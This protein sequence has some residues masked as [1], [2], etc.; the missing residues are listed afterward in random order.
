LRFG[1]LQP[2]LLAA[3]DGHLYV[4]KFQNNPQ[5][6][7]VLA[8][9]MIA[10]RIALWLDLPMAHVC[11]IEVSESLVA[12]NPLLR[13]ECES[14]SVPCSSGIQLGSRCVAHPDTLLNFDDLNSAQ[15]ESVNNLD[16]FTQVLVFDRW[17]GNCDGRQAVVPRSLR[18]KH[19]GC[20]ATFIDQHYCFNGQAWDFPDLPHTGLCPK[21]SVYRN[22]RGWESFEPMLSRLEAVDAT[23][24]WRLARETPAQWYE[25]N[26][27]ALSELIDTLDK[28]RSMVSRLIQES[29]NSCDAP[30]TNWTR[31]AFAFAR[32]GIAG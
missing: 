16:E 3:S 22:V 23:D 4:T 12:Q 1:N 20:A 27:G 24:L 14:S 10:T 5:G 28:R 29:R 30:F 11:P 9:E 8:S 15:V 2:H 7:R 31:S 19:Q 32:P 17:A 26:H 18:R 25:D 21:S 13:I 6:L